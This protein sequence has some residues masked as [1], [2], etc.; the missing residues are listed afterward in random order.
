LAAIATSSF[1]DSACCSRSIAVSR[2]I[3]SSPA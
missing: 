1:A 2:V 3:F